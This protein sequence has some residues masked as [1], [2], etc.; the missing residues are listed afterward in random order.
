MNEQIEALYSEIIQKLKNHQRPQIRLS[1]EIIELIREVWS[2]A[3][4]EGNNSLQSS[5]LKKIFCILDN[6]QTT[7]SEFNGPFISTLKE[8]KNSEIIIYCLA[9]SQKHLIADS[10]KTGKMIHFEF[11]EIC[12]H[13]LKQHQQYP[14]YQHRHVLAA[15]RDFPA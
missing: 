10:L 9:A 15:T 4:E 11:F 3:L 5:S 8:V 6:T 12:D 13:G 7:T 14:C 1:P 2:K